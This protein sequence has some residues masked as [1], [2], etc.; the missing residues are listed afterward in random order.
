MG[1]DRACSEIS[2]GTSSY[3]SQKHLFGE[4]RWNQWIWGDGNSMA[5]HEGAMFQPLG[6]FGR[7][8]SHHCL[9]ISETHVTYVHDESQIP[10]SKVARGLGRMLRKEACLL[11]RALCLIKAGRFEMFNQTIPPPRFFFPSNHFNE[12]LEVDLS[13]SIQISHIHTYPTISAISRSFLFYTRKVVGLKYSYDPHDPPLWMVH[14][15]VLHGG[16]LC[17]ISHPHFQTHSY[18]FKYQVGY[19]PTISYCISC[20]ALIWCLHILSPRFL[21]ASKPFQVH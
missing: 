5:G 21:L 1:I 3:I 13:K 2:A 18:I 9:T 6:G 4:T 10:A 15:L 16:W 14:E 11:N 12:Y 17:I 7:Q 19:T 20:N 8:P